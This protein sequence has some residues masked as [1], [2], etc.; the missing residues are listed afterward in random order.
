[1]M[2]KGNKNSVKD[3]SSK[4]CTILVVEDDKGLARLIAKSL[5]NT[6]F[7]AGVACNGVQAVDLVVNNPVNLMLLDYKL[8]DMSARQV[9]ETIKERKIEI[10]FIIMTGHG[11]EKVAVEMMKTGARDYIVKE[12]KF[13]ELLPSVVKRVFEELQSEKKLIEA[14]EALVKSEKEYRS[15][16]DN[17]LVGIYKININGEILYVN[18][19]LSN[20]FEYASPEEMM[21]GNILKIFK[22]TNS[23]KTVL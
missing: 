1:M 7:D 9:V 14:S 11:D 22:N 5:K 15:L 4:P 16:V 2:K 12:G 8:P 6:G 18:R 20:M 10:P 23:R 21:S 17:A 3:A 19:A 13:F